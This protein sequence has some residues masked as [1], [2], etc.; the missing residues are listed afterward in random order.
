QGTAAFTAWFRCLRSGVPVFAFEFPCC[1]LLVVGRL[2]ASL[3]SFK[4]PASLTPIIPAGFRFPSTRAHR[5]FEHHH[6][7]AWH[8]AKQADIEGMAILNSI[9]RGHGKLKDQGQRATGR[10][11]VPSDGVD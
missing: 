2:S 3:Q 5:H 6:L 4:A 9:H 1:L 11:G 10:V 7:D 8:L